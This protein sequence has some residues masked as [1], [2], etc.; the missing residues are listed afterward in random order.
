MKTKKIKN[1]LNSLLLTTIGCTVGLTGCITTMPMGMPGMMPGN[2]GASSPVGAAPQGSAPTTGGAN[3]A[4][5]KVTG[6]GG[7]SGTDAEKFA[8]NIHQLKIGQSTK[9]DAIAVLG[10]PAQ[11]S[12]TGQIDSWLYHL[13]STNPIP[14]LANVQFKN[15][16]LAFVQVTKT[17]FAGGGMESEVIFT[18]GEYPK[19]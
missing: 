18:K 11:K 3:W 9:E 17:E 7:L 14:A 4:G 15:N 5:P 1:R 13:K 2:L 12:K 16:Y 6:R 10:S 8:S 19:P